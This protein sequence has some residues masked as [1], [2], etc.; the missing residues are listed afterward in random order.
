MPFL[1][2]KT[3]NNSSAFLNGAIS[4]S[5]GSL[6]VQPG[7]GAEFPS[8]YP[9]LLTLENYD[10]SGVVTKREIV[11]VSNRSGDTFTIVRSVGTC[12]P[13]DVSSTQGTTAFAFGNNDTV[14]LNMTS[15]VVKD[16]QDEVARLET[17]KANQTEVNAIKA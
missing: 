14:R 3:S 6:T 11:K 9:Y 7:Q 12:P 17:A 4:A 8:S 15:E 16:I 2:Y 1:N 13:S 5:A 10:L